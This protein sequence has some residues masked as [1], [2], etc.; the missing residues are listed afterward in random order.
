MTDETPPV[1]PPASGRGLGGGPAQPFK[2]RNTVRAKALR[3]TAPAA[4]RLLWQQL[5]SK[6]LGYKFSRQM[7]V[8]PYFADF[9]CRELKLIVELDG[10]SHDFRPVYDAQRT[11][12]CIAHGYQILRFSNADVMENLEGVVTHIKTTLAKAHPRPLPQ[13]GGE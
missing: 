2:P 6:K 10:E 8:G 13:A 7:P 1:P 5:R 12:Y 11:E 9:L 4:E 3:N